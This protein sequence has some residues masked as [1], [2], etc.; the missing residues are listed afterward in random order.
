MVIEEPKLPKNKFIHE[1]VT[2]DGCGVKPIIGNRWK[3]AV[4]EDFDYCDKCESTKEH[5]HPFLKIKCEEQY[6]VAITVILPEEKPAPKPRH[7]GCK[8]GNLIGK[9]MNHVQS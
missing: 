1:R 7:G 8:I 5:A 2:C 6:P 3:C 9:F 4:C